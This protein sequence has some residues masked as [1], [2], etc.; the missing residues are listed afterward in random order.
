MI[1]G[2]W[3][4]DKMRGDLINKDVQEYLKTFGDTAPVSI[5][6]ADAA[7]RER[8]VGEFAAI[9]DI[10]Q[11]VFIFSIKDTKKLDEKEMLAAEEAETP[12]VIYDDGTDITYKCAACGQEYTQQKIYR[13]NYCSYCGQFFAWKEEKEA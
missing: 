2:K 9:T 11:P 12:Q 7:K 13:A 4:G 5:I 1:C 3:K 10:G 8:Y 6:V